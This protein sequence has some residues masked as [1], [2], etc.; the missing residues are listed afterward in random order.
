MQPMPVAAPAMPSAPIVRPEA[1]ASVTP[2]TPPAPTVR[3]DAASTGG[4]SVGETLDY[5]RIPAELDKKFESLDTDGALRATILKPGDPWT[6]TAQKGLLGS[7]S[8]QV[9]GTTEQRTEKHRAFDLLDA[10]SKSGALAIDDASLHVV[11]AATHCF[12]KTL[13]DTVIQDN[14]NP[15][16]KVERSLLIV[17]TT[18]H[19]QSAIAMLAPEQRD[20]FLTMSPQLA[21]GDDA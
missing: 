6:R 5:T 21:S 18:I 3:H 1:A 14:V 20:R 8:T 12:D 19:A 13:V 7:P 4:D 17:G 11:L 15:I 9:M 10:L 16:E 2:P